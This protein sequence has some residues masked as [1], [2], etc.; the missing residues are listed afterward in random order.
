MAILQMDLENKSLLLS[1][2]PQLPSRL[3]TAPHTSRPSA[4]AQR[5]AFVDRA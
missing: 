2:V 4:Q 5:G 3:A 1:L